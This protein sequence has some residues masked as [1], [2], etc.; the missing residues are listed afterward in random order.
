[1]YRL[2]IRLCLA[3]RSM[4]FFKDVVASLQLRVVRIFGAFSGQIH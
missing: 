3:A 2:K 1:M 4:L